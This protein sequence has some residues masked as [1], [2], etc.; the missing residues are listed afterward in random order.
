MPP[1]L[2]I[3]VDIPPDLPPRKGTVASE[4]ESGHSRNM[5]DVSFVSSTSH[6]SGKITTY[7]ARYHRLLDIVLT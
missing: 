3:Q 7:V 2:V 4:E 5:S 1:S 6:S